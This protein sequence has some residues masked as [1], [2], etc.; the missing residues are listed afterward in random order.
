[1]PVIPECTRATL[2]GRKVTELKALANGRSWDINTGHDLMIT[3]P[4]AAAELLLGLAS[5]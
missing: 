2:S 1:V 5:V 3:E 4:D